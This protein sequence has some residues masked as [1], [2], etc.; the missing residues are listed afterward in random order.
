MEESKGT[1]GDAYQ[2]RIVSNFVHFERNY[3]YMCRGELAL[4]CFHSFQVI[5]TWCGMLHLAELS[6][7]CLFQY[8]RFVYF[9][10]LYWL[11]IREVCV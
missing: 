9:L 10:F 3:V 5:V 2:N 11:H 7:T 8:H 6:R 1:L 4:F